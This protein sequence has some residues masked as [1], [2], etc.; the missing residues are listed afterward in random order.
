MFENRNGTKNVDFTN[1]WN[2][3]LKVYNGV[4][5]CKLG[6]TTHV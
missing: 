3:I 2:D 4:L 1:K 6:K 5:N